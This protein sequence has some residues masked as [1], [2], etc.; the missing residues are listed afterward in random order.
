LRSDAFV[1]P[2]RAES[3][4]AVYTLRFIRHFQLDDR[5]RLYREIRRV[6]RPRGVFMVDALNRDV[7]LPYRMKRGIESY[8]IYDVLYR[9]DELEAELQ[10]AGF[11]IVALEGIIKH[12][13]VQQ[14]LNRLRRLRLNGLATA[15]IA[16]LER[17]PGSNPSN[18]MLLC[19]KQS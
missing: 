15:L 17:I 1:L 14:R 9:R 16:S 5:Q 3:F 12:F 13:G 2:F 4:D 8:H 19:E 7:S 11:R 18:W 6:L 10:A